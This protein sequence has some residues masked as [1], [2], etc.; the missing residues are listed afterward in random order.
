MRL[1]IFDKIVFTVASGVICIFIL[2]RFI[3]LTEYPAGF[4]VDESSIGYNAQQILRTHTDEHGAYLPLYFEAFGDY[5][6]PFFVY[7]VIPLI[8]LFGEHVGSIR[9]AAALWVVA[10]LAAFFGLFK[11]MGF[12]RQ[13]LIAAMLLCSTSPWLIQLGRVG[14]EVASAPVFIVAAVIA[15]YRATMLQSTHEPSWR[16]WVY[17]FVAACLLG[18]Y[19][20]T[21]LRLAMPVLL[22]GGLFLIR[23]NLSLQMSL[24]IF[25]LA[26]TICLPLAMSKAVTSGA[27]SA[28]YAVVGLSHYTRTGAEFL[29]AFTTNALHHFSPAFLY[30][31]GDGNLRHIPAPYGVFFTAALPFFVV[32]LWWLYTTRKHVFSQWLALS[33]CVGIIPSALTIQSPHVL[34]AVVFLTVAY[35]IAGLGVRFALEHLGWLRLVSR[36]LIVVLCVQSY[37]FLGFYTHT[38]A[39]ASRIWFD[40]GT[41]EILADVDH[42]T[43][44]VYVST[45]LYPGT[46]ATAYFFATAHH[47]DLNVVKF[48]HPST[49]TILS[50]GTYVLEYDSCQK[51]VQIHNQS[52]TFYSDGICVFAVR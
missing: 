25:L 5:K 39:Q 48:V 26:I 32:G 23:K 44:P 47:L 45:Q 50:S 12:R 16:I 37:V 18:F 36:L 17:G 8:V 22:M 3:F 15:Y 27:L 42:Y 31:G 30:A 34:R 33:M 24:K 38:Y 6:N 40:A 2:F 46:Y 9:M 51:L 4:F 13:T 1:H 19:S 35:V 29:S 52:L 14:F 7:S 20:Y 49:L 10:A 28:R 11:M 41:A 21:S 43:Q